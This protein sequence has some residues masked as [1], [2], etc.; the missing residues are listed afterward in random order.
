MLRDEIIV[1]KLPVR[2]IN[3]RVLVKIEDTFS[4]FKT[5]GGIDLV[6]LTTEDTWG[7]SHQYNISEFVPRWGEVIVAPETVTK[8]SFNYDTDVE[9]KPG[10]I[11]FWSLV[12]FQGHIPIVY[13]KQ[14]YLL[15]DYHEILCLYRNNEIIPVNGYG[16]FSAVE[17]EERALTFVKKNK[18]SD[19]WKLKYLPHKNVRYADRNRQPADIW[20]PGDHV[21]LVVRSSPF[22]IEGT[23]NKLIDEELYA[24]PMNFIICSL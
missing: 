13:N 11:V 15:V 17:T 8:G 10:D 3:N 7:D 2:V 5:K 12:S 6:N 22:K 18:V 20:E 1:D 14:R 19:I 4:G 24:C 9:V 21:H 23:I 16:L